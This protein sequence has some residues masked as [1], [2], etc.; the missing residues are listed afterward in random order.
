M[1]SIP[2]RAL[3]ANLCDQRSSVFQKFAR[4]ILSDFT[5]P[6][7]EDLSKWSLHISTRS[8][9]HSI[10]SRI[11]IYTGS[12]VPY[13]AQVLGKLKSAFDDFL[14]YLLYCALIT[15]RWVLPFTLFPKVIGAAL[16]YL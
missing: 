8:V 3:S 13:L 7:H 12:N 11:H 9:F 4:K 6:L 1:P 10:P 5:L 14:N 15:S 2:I 16:L